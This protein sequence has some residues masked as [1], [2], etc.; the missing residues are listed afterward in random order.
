MWAVRWKDQPWIRLACSS[1]IRRSLSRRSFSRFSANSLWCLRMSSFRF[2]LLSASICLCF[3]LCSWSCRSCSRCWSAFDFLSRSTIF[4]DSSMWRLLA[5]RCC[6]IR[7]FSCVLLISVSRVVFNLDCA[8]DSPR[9]VKTRATMLG[10][11]AT[12]H[13]MPRFVAFLQGIDLRCP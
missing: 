11:Q 6:S 12:T 9:H 2:L 13:L 1:A 5:L 4:L 10:V 7:F 8:R 3:S